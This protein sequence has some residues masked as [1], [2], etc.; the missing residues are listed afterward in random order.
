MTAAGAGAATARHRRAGP[1]PLAGWYAEF[2]RHGLPWRRTRDRWAVLVSE[3]M[4]QQ[5]QVERVAAV[6][7]AFMDRFPT[8]EAM[9]AAPAGEVIAAWGRLG[10]PQRARRLWEA[11]GL[12]NA[13]GWPEDLTT[14]PGVGRYTADA[15][16]AQVDDAD[17]PAVE[18]NIRRVVERRAGRHLTPAE[19]AV[20]G[21]EAGRPLRGRDRLLALMDVGAVLCRPQAPDCGPCPLSP[22]CATASGTAAVGWRALGAR[23]RQP[24]YEGSFRQRRGEVLARL[25][26]G[27][28]DAASLD[29]E[30]LAS[31]VADGL[32]ALDGR[33]ARLP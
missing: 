10:Y 27:P 29:P 21:R 3:V 4:L 2:G 9:A 12:I 11:A 13:G 24:A 31:L 18:T 8:P 7:P 19:A 6:W 20:G 26:A 25:R 17:A 28:H 5:T 22:G 30:A 1:A 23:S 32:A 14:L 16:A 33:L 15:V